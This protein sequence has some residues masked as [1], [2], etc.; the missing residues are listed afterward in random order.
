MCVTRPQWVKPSWWR[1]Q[2][3][4]FSALLDIC[5]GNSPVP[6]A[7][8]FS[9]ICVWINGWENN[10]EA[11]DLRSYRAHYDV[12][13][14]MWVNT[15]YS[16]LVP[17][18]TRPSAGTVMHVSFKALRCRLSILL[19]QAWSFGTNVNFITVDDFWQNTQNSPVYNSCMCTKFQLRIKSDVRCNQNPN[20]DFYFYLQ[21]IYDPTEINTVHLAKPI[22]VI[23]GCY[24]L[25]KAANK[26]DRIARTT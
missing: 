21:N 23:N 16:V 15:G 8:M 6:G 14:V 5:A 1:H 12:I 18:V 2:M 13:V 4:T 25:G 10:R 17:H 7:L 11:G 22:Y 26:N 3:E 9:L 20:T 24:P 19:L